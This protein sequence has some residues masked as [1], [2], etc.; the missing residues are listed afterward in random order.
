MMRI[1]RYL[2]LSSPVHRLP[3]A[4]KL[5]GLVLAVV[6][7]VAA[8]VPVGLVVTCALVALSRVPPGEAFGVVWALRWFCVSVLALNALFFS[9]ARPL[10]VLGPA[11]LTWEGLAQGVRVVCRL[12]LVATLGELLCAT[13]RPQQVVSGV[14]DLLS[15]L[16]RLGVPVEVA[17]LTVGVTVQFV[18]TL[19]D[20]CTHLARAQRLRAARSAR[21]R[22]PHRAWAYLSGYARLLVPIFVAAFRRA[23]DLSVAMEAR[24]YR[25]E[26]GEKEVR[27]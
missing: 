6:L 18:P 24:G 14:R 19:M 1:G 27:G 4:A 20:E 23:D 2:P 12:S 13:T 21:L 25:L 15:P 5:V 10:L 3:G 7:V 22:G 16:A 26:S 9:G 17:A 11:T 8:P